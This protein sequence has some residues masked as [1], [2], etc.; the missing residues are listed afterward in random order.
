VKLFIKLDNLVGC[1]RRAGLLTVTEG[2]I[3]YPYLLG[4]T[5]G[6]ATVVKGNLRH[7]VVRIYLTV[8]IRLVNVLQGIFV[9]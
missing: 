1:V 6:Y 7:L 4:H 2:G 9:L 5:K 3:G 8:K